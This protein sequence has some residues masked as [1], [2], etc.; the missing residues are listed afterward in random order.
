M[1][2]CRAYKINLSTHS[3]LKSLTHR[4]YAFRHILQ[5]VRLLEVK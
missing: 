4:V 1:L 2:G 3:L 5:N